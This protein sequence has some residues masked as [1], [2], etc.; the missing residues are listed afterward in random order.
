M[1]TKQLVLKTVQFFYQ[2]NRYASVERLRTKGRWMN[3]ELNE[4]DKDTD[5]QEKK[6]RE[7]QRMKGMKGV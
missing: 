3:A 1:K 4:R 7:N 2:R 6:E 5:K